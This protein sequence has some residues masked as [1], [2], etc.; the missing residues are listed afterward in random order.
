MNND[1]TKLEQYSQIQAMV[2]KEARAIAEQVYKENATKYGV[3][4]V[5][6]HRHN[7]VDS[8]KISPINLDGFLPINGI[9]SGITTQESGVF[10][11]AQAEDD[12][13][14]VGGGVTYSPPVTYVAP[15]PIIYGHGVGTGS[16][17]SGGDTNVGS[18]LYFRNGET[19]NQLWVYCDDGK[20]RGVNLPLTV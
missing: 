1:Q 15:V 11:I 13:F 7:G 19:V 17:F 8:P 14:N 12:S 16:Q 2:Q 5:P 4:K 10:A 3:A 18:M 9:G 20:W 6:L